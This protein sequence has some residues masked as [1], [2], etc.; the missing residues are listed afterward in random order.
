MLKFIVRRFCSYAVML[1]LATSGVYFLA[2]WFLDPRSNYL[3]LR[4]KP[5]I[6]SINAS[7]DYAN[8]N[9]QVPLLERYWNWL[10]DIVLHWNWGYSP[11]GEPVSEIIWDRAWVSVQ[12]V[13]ISTALA[14][15]IGIAIGVRS[16]IRKYGVFDHVSNSVSVVFLVMPSFVLALLVVLVYL[17]LQQ[18]FDLHWFAVTGL[19]DGSFLGYV[20]HL[21][22][23]TLVLT[24][25]GYVG[26]HLTQRTYLLD[27]MNADYVRTARAKGVPRTLAIRRHAL[28]TSMIPTAYGVA[29]SITGTVTGAVFVEQIFAI[30]GAGLYFIETLAKNDI[31]GAVSV[32][33]L[34]GVA[35]CA[36][37]LLADI[38][39][40]FL[41]PRIRIS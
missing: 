25:I 37:L 10:T 20:Q 34:G 22:L 36:G 29:F 24:L 13:A 1:F 41:D 23:P 3:A 30:H 33:F 12:L 4:P 35:T 38:F 7:L 28:R 9:D 16:A 17:N 15:V 32:A 31:N 27:T 8:I 39:V 26:F 14:V 11:V 5:P 21:F 19:G 2:S 6:E 18:R 40:A